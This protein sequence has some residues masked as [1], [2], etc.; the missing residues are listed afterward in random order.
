MAIGA[1]LVIAAV[2][3]TILAWLLK[4]ILD[5]L[6]RIQ[7]PFLARFTRLWLVKQA[8]YGDFHKVNVELHRRYGPVVRIRPNEYSID[9]PSAVKP[10][11]GAGTKFIKGTWYS[12][13]TPVAV[14]HLNLFALQ[15]QKQHGNLRKKYS[16]LYSVSSLVR[17]ESVVDKNAR[18]LA[19]HLRT[20]VESGD[21]IDL[22]HWLQCYAFDVITEITLGYPLGFLDKGQDIDRLMSTTEETLTYGAI[23]GFFPTLHHFTNKYLKYDPT[24]Q[25]Q[26]INENEPAPF[27]RLFQEKQAEAPDVYTFE[28]GV[29]LLSQNLAAGSDTTGISLAAAFYW[30]LQHPHCIQRLLNDIRETY[31]NKRED[32]FFTFQETQTIPYLQAIIKEVLRLHPATGL[33]MARLVPKGGAEIAGVH[34]PEGATVGINAW[35]AHHNKEVFGPDADDFRPERWLD[36]EPDVLSAMERYFLAF[37]SGSR[38]CIGKNI[39]YLEISKLKMGLSQELASWFAPPQIETLPP[40]Q[41]GQPAPSTSK[42]ALPAE[43]GKPTIVAFLR[44]CGCPDA[45]KVAEATFIEMRT[46]AT[47]HRDINFVAVSHSDQASTEKWVEAIRED[48]ESLTDSVTVIVDADREIY[49][50][51]GL[52]V[53]SWGHLLSPTAMHAI[54]KLGSEKGIWNRPTESGSRWQ[55]SGHWAIDEKGIVRWGG[56]AARVDEVIDISQ[57]IGALRQHSS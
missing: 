15:D 54:Y 48:E 12:A 17:Y 31:P 1:P 43:N 36:S 44:H 45:F 14:A 11:Y 52:G 18:K 28:I 37:G 20:F 51:W 9:N 26:R 4:R 3:Y 50:Q 46:A 23:A 13:S 21:R 56:P 33:P 29:T 7:G 22:M 55:S 34:F 35:V 32:E 39:S 40:P 19:R 38:T 57:A 2:V 27:A 10:L 47:Q 8:W 53:V 16:S 6:R 30:L 24:N 49:A 5:P 42:L 41:V 25:D